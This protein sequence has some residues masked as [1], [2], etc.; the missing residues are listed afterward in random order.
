M[1]KQ[2]CS[3][4]AVQLV[5]VI[6]NGP[7]IFSSLFKT[8]F[9]Q[10]LVMTNFKQIQTNVVKKISNEIVR[11]LCKDCAEHLVFVNVVPLNIIFFNYLNT[12]I[13]N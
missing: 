9:S 4:T 3:C 13:A 8:F 12:L 5:L 1:K 10:L 11:S 7:D 2:Y 6:G